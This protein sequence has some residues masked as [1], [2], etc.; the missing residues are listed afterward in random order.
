MI[1]FDR[2]KGEILNDANVVMFRGIWAGH[3]AHANVVADERLKGLGPLPGG[4]YSF[5]QARDSDTLG[6]LVMNLDPA[7]GTDTFGRS[8]FRIHGDTANDTGHEASDGCIIAPHNVRDWISKQHD[9]RL[10]VI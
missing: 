5:E 2:T 3:E 4:M 9:R 10:L 1:K 8:L 6:P 7:P